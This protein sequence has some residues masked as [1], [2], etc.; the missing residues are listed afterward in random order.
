MR[1]KEPL[2]KTSFSPTGLSS[3]E[4]ALKPRVVSSRQ[5]WCVGILVIFILLSV[6]A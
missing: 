1:D 4:S 6:W 2:E 5:K 3:L